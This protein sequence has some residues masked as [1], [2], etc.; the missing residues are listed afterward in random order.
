MRFVDAATGAARVAAALLGWR[1]D[2]FW[3]ATP[4]DLRTA[5]GL[6]LTAETPADAG[7]L[8]RLMEAFPDD[9]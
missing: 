1:P 6:D 3:A 2:D 5:L 4:A 9:K 8:T 7:L